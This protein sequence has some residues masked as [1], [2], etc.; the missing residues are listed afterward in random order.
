MASLINSALY[1]ANRFLFAKPYLVGQSAKYKLKFRFKAQDAIGRKIF[2]SGLYEEEISNF[3][4]HELPWQDDD[5]I[6]DVGANIGWYSLLLASKIPHQVSIYAFEPE[7]ENFR[8]LEYNLEKNHISAVQAYQQGI[9]DK[10]ETKILHLY[11]N[12]NTGRHSMLDINGADTIE[13]KTTSLDLFL[14]EKQLE[15]KRV[16][17]LKIDIEGF[18]Y[19]AFKG[20]HQLLSHL[21]YIMAEFSPGYMRKGGLEPAELLELLYSYDYTPH[22]ITASGL[23]KLEEEALLKTNSNINIFWIKQGHALPE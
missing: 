11:K 19:F 15:A 22:N 3:L 21:P 9:S 7:P 23:E 8:C 18:E 2:K 5:I 4:I 17:L 14:A 10:E 20:A 12:S 16:K 6:L 13:V 1:L